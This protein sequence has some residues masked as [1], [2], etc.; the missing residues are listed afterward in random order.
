MA[1]NMEIVYSEDREVKYFLNVSVHHLAA[2]FVVILCFLALV[3]AAIP[4]IQLLLIG[5]IIVKEAV[6]KSVLL[7]TVLLGCIFHP[8]LRLK[9]LP[10]VTWTLCVLYLLAEI[11]YLMLSRGQIFEHVLLSYHAYYLLLLLAP[12]LLAFRD[13]V[14]E[15]TIIRWTVV[16]FLICA[17]LGFAQHFTGQPIL[18][19]EAPDGSFDIPSWDFFGQVRAFSFFSASMNFGIFCAL[20]GALGVALSRK[21]PIKGSLLCFLSGLACLTTLTRLCYLVFICACT[22]AAVLTFGKKPTRARWHPFL[23]FGLGMMT[24]LFGLYSVVSETGD[25]QDAGSLLQRIEQWTYYYELLLHSTLVEKI[26]G[27]G[28]V[29]LAKVIPV[30]PM[31]IDNLFLALILHIGV[32]GLI[33]FGILLVKML[34]YLRRQALVTQQPFII[35]AA[36]LWATLACAGIFNILF[37]SFGVVFALV[38][39]CKKRTLNTFDTTQISN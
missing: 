19:T 32:L 2:L 1:R 24:V 6:V 33:L 25:L 7:A 39:L 26:F 30:Y 20:C 29:Q 28:I 10:M 15:R 21:M 36:S 31:I 9:E 17:A 12:A 27:F 23:Y 37:S 34:L 13:A 3:D 38:L 8:T 5:E 14:S 4:Q 35:A 16:I 11:P 22:Y 18:R